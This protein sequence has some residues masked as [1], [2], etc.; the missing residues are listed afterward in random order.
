MQREERQSKVS[1]DKHPS[2]LSFNEKAQSPCS[3]CLSV[4]QFHPRWQ[5][6]SRPAQSPCRSSA[7]TSN[8]SR[9]PVSLTRAEASKKKHMQFCDS[10]RIICFQPTVYV[11]VPLAMKH[12][13]NKNQHLPALDTWQSHVTLVTR[14]K[15]YQTYS[16]RMLFF[17]GLNS[18]KYS[19]ELLIYISGKCRIR[20]MASTPPI[21]PHLWQLLP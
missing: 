10:L 5:R 2:P 3:K 21:L 19:F 12:T 15:T 8:P 18:Y 13:S 1:D 7:P 20:A 16:Y 17:W 4:Q 14:S 9:A 6:S 11:L